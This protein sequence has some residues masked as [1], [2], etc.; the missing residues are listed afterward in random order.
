MDGVAPSEAIQKNSGGVCF[1]VECATSILLVVILVK[2]E[3]AGSFFVV[4]VNGVFW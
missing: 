3:E 1:R 4:D 2:T